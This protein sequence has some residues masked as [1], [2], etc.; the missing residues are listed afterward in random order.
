LNIFDVVPLTIVV[1]GGVKQK[2]VGRNETAI[3]TA[4]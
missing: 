4:L 3:A 1:G 2:M